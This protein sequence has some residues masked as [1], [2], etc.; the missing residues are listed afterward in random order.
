MKIELLEQDLPVSG[1][2]WALLKNEYLWNAFTA[3]TQDPSSPHY[4]LDDIWAR[5]GEPKDAETGEAHEAK[6]YPS[7]DVLGI[8]PLCSAIYERYNGI[9]LGGVLITRIK[10]GKECLP[11]QDQ[12]W[13][14]RHYEK[15][16]VQIT[17]A[18]NQLFCFEDEALETQPG[19]LFRFD[20]AFMHWVTNPTPYDRITLIICMR[21]E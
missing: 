17:S 16:A 4:G 15:F 21:R 9:E 12:G 7:A 11:H 14:A 5:F 1:I 10:A 13:H 8:K 3:R 20:N 6:W 19:D 2:H 18:P